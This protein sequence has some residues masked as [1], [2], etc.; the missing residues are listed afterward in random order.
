MEDAQSQ[1]TNLRL[2]ITCGNG[3]RGIYL[4][5]P[6]QLE[7]PS[8]FSITVDPK[9]M[10][11]RTGLFLFNIPV[12][13]FFYIRYMLEDITIDWMSGFLFSDSQVKID[14]S[15]RFALAC[16]EPWVEYPSHLELMN[17]ARTFTVKVDPRGLQHGAYYTEVVIDC[18]F[19]VVKKEWITLYELRQYMFGTY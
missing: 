14:F 7:K 9:F 2:G 3:S 18:Q 17:V 16:D 4:R 5:E 12:M 6:H 19:L 10:D 11:E 15:V 13:V 8:E 1:S